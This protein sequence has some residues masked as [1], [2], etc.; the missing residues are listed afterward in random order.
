MSSLNI[1][2]ISGRLT[3][4]AELTYTNG[5][6]AIV[7]MSLAVGDRKKKGEAWTD[8]AYFFD[9][10][11][12]GK[13]GESI[14][15]Y[16]VKGKQINVSGKLVQES[17]E[18][19]GEKKSKILIEADFIELIGSRDGGQLQQDSSVRTSAQRSGDEFIDD[20]PF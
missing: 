12:I 3:R 17:W 16:L 5:G 4:D 2:T 15:K 18:K 9:V 11:I 10:K 13:Y 14:A 1:I 7:K 20:M 19:D 6:M 8:I